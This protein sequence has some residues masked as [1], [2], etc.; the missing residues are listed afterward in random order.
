MIRKNDIKSLLKIPALVVLA[1]LSFSCGPDIECPDDTFLNLRIST[2]SDLYNRTIYQSPG[3][4]DSIPFEA[5]VVSKK[6]KLPLRD[7]TKLPLDVS[8]R[9]LMFITETKKRNDTLIVTYD[10]QR[11]ACAS[12]GRNGFYIAVIKLETKKNTFND[13][14]SNIDISYNINTL[15]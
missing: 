11:H 12:S 8:S 4:I 15:Y 14:T 10:F 2:K 7:L 9:E 13:S 6:R 3:I 5:F 1:L